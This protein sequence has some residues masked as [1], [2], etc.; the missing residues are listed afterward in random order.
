MRQFLLAQPEP[1]DA[2]VTPG[3]AEQDLRHPARKIQEHQVGGGLGQ[4]AQGGRDRAGQSRGRGRHPR[5]DVPDRVA[6]DQQQLAFLQGLG[7][8]G[9]G[10]AVDDPELAQ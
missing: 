5:A 3:L 6:R 2:V 7:V 8:G 4:A 9:A 1:D 10:A